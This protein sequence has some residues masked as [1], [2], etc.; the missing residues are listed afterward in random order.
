MADP[1]TAGPDDEM[2]S[3]P[4]LARQAPEIPLPVDNPLP[5]LVEE[6]WGGCAAS[7]RSRLPSGAFD[8]FLRDLSRAGK[9][10]GFLGGLNSLPYTW[11]CG[12]RRGCVGDARNE[13]SQPDL[14]R[15]RTE[16]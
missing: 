4:A 8:G 13:L 16:P 2:V 9:G 10:D 3:S 7:G 15:Q 12:L 1:P 14:P 5:R 6:S 11:R